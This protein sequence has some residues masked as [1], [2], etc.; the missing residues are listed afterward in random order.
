MAATNNSKTS[1]RDGKNPNLKGDEVII[2]KNSVKSILDFLVAY[3]N[4]IRGGP[5][6]ML[7]GI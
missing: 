4:Q 2:V 3:L 5:K 6:N 7:N 1:I